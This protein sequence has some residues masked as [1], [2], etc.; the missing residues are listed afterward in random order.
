MRIAALYDIH[1][2]LPALD[3]ALTDVDNAGAD[4]VVVGGDIVWGPMPQRVLERLDA[5]DNVTFIRGNADREV[6]G[7]EGPSKDDFGEITA[8]VR[9]M[10][11]EEQAAWLGGLPDTFATEVTG[12]GEVLFCHGSPRSDDEA[13]TPLSP[14][15]RLEDAL[16]GVGQ[17]TV[18]CGHT[19]MQ[20]RRTVAGR[21]IVN[22]GSVGLPYQGARGAYWLLLGPHIELRRT[23]Y[24][25][26]ATVRAMRATDCPHVDE[27]FVANLLEPPEAEATARHF[28]GSE[29]TIS[30]P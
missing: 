1:G 21:E 20:F 27:V 2:N 13:I 9:S 10:L 6:A 12:M 17:P 4:L 26:E 30:R 5:L 14:V 3:A 15:E 18:V 24:D 16:S 7:F 8:W 23:D 19:H 28:E 11:S 25:V 22:A 29:A